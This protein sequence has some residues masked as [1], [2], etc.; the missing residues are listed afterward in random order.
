MKNKPDQPELSRPLAI[1]KI[2]ANG[3]EE[4]ILADPKERKKLAARFGLLD[5]PKLEAQFDVKPA[6]GGSMFEITGNMRADVVQ[7]CVVTL[8]PLPA[9]IEQPITVLYATPEMLETGEDPPHESPQGETEAIVDGIIDLGELV[10]QYLGTALDPYPRKPGA[11][12][13]EAEYGDATP[14]ANPF[15]KLVD[16]KEPKK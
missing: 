13:V 10:A 14:E 2:P 6:R 16:L 15:A 4:T 8:E 1:D 5:L 9:H 3:I 11:A 12:F 7:Q